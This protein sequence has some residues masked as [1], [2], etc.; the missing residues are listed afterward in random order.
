MNDRFNDIEG[1]LKELEARLE[2]LDAWKKEKEQT[3][4]VA[5]SKKE[6]K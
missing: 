3:V 4:P 2:K 5:K 1:K 6:P